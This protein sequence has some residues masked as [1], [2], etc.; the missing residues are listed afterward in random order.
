M[1]GSQETFNKK[2]KE[3]KRLKKRLEKQQ[4]LADRKANSKGGGFDNMVAY[5]DENGNIT[6]TPPDPA[7]RKIIDVDSIKIGVPKR[8][9]EEINPIRNG[10]VEYFNHS[11]GFGFIKDIDT[12][13]K[14]FVHVNNLT[15]EINE[16]DMV[17]FEIERGFKGMSA[18]RVKKVKKA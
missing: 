3:K 9:K 13:Q 6:D 17:T 14:Y 1:A 8:E 18:V 11:K 16:S 5:V 12:Q 15:E 4:K 10:R 2:E 7:D